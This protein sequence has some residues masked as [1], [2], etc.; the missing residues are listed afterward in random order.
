MLDAGT[1]SSANDPT[2]LV[3]AVV[4]ATPRAVLE[5]SGTTEEEG[6]VERSVRRSR[7][8]PLEVLIGRTKSFLAILRHASLL[9]GRRL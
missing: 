9:V 3:A 5:S 8:G 6:K 2:E 4:G 7:R 1:P